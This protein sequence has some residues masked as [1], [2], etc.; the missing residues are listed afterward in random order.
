MPHD[1]RRVLVLSNFFTQGHGGTPESV[2]LL[3]RELA[4]RGMSVDVFCRNGLLRGVQAHDALPAASD[5]GVFS[6]EMPDT[7]SYSALF[8]AGSWNRRAP[9]IALR[10]A[11]EGIPIVYA[12]KG[13]LCRAEFAQWRDMRRIPYFLL[14]EWLL[15][16]L[17]RKIVFSSRTE[18]RGS[19][20][21]RWL[22]ESRAVLLPEPFRGGQLCSD[23]A[24]DVLTLGFLAEISP[25][26]G[27]YELIAGLGHYLACRR[28]AKIRLRIAGAARRGSE[29]Y[30][31]KCRSL[32]ADNGASG[33]IEW[34]GSVRGAQRRDF[35][36]SLDL[37]MCP[38]QF[39]SFGLTPLEALW[40]GRAVCIAPAAGVLEYLC[41]DAPVLR[42]PAL[43]KEGVA[44]AIA[45]VADNIEAWRSKGR[46]WEGRHSLIRANAEIADD[47][48]RV[49]LD[50]KPA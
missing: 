9:P 3:A 21:P 38:S 20:L 5:I 11:M 44:A 15:L 2:L 13:C 10:A 6:A 28:G 7:K 18:Q 39:E 35:Y 34:C 31:E 16:A 14:V 26:K 12:A 17:A 45:E 29:A 50:A 24:A 30:L 25:R 22:W 47:F 4:G 37:F 27:L 19:V 1:G 41:P 23:K 46:A 8:I 42:L 48:A 43:S 32:A 33:Q 49:L 40:Q 36:R